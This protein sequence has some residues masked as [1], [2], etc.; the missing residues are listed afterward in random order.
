[1]NNKQ[2]ALYELS[3]KS[4]GV[5]Y[6][7]WFL[8]GFTGL[9]CLYAK[10]VGHFLF[11]LVCLLGSMVFPPLFVISC[12]VFFLDLFLTYGMVKDYN[13]KLLTAMGE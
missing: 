3:K 12:I 4:T 13:T 11:R 6:I 1:M 2:L 8:L 7:L 10:E 5:A 9:H